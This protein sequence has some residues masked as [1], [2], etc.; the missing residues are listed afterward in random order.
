MR[1]TMTFAIVAA[2]GLLGYQSPGQADVSANAKLTISVVDKDAKSVTDAKVFVVS[3]ADAQTFKQ[4]RKN[5][6]AKGAKGAKK[7]HRQ[8]PGVPA[9]L[10]NDGKYVAD[11]A[12]GEY[13]VVA[14]EKGIGHGHE[15]VNVNAGGT[16]TTVTLKAKG[17]H[18]AGKKRHNAAAAPA[19]PAAS[20]PAPAAVPAPSPAAN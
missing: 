3:A 12:P 7:E 19:N 2:M 18:H 10:G 1:R 4:D 5:G 9:Q 20:D 8:P 6:H 13:V 17:E 15:S 11:V 14:M 16:S